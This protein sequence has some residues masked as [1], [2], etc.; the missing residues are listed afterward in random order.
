MQQP[1]HLDALRAFMYNITHSRPPHRPTSPR[2]LL[3]PSAF[4]PLRCRPVGAII[5]SIM[6][7]E[8]TMSQG[9][10][11]TVETDALLLDQVTQGTLSRQV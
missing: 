9:A 8:T 5:E 10:E 1:A 7:V 2:P 11:S 6:L 3:G 4:L